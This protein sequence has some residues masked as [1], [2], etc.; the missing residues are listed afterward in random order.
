MMTIYLPNAY[1]ML[2]PKISKCHIS[3]TLLSLNVDLIFFSDT[4]YSFSQILV[5][6][7]SAFYN[8]LSFAYSVMNS[9]VTSVMDFSIIH[10]TIYWFLKITTV[11]SDSII[12]GL[13]YLVGNR[14]L[15]L[16]IRSFLSLVTLGS[17]FKECTE[18]NNIGRF[19]ITNNFIQYSLQDNR[20]SASFRIGIDRPKFILTTCLYMTSSSINFSYLSADVKIML[21]YNRFLSEKEDFKMKILVNVLNTYASPILLVNIF[22]IVFIRLLSCKATNIAP[23]FTPIRKAFMKNSITMAVDTPAAKIIFQSSRRIFTSGVR[24]GILSDICH[25]STTSVKLEDALHNKRD[26]L[27]HKY[28]RLFLNY[29]ETSQFVP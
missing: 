23:S 17:W 8:F 2:S 18:R 22:F 5:H 7:E 26:I 10:V 11:A 1:F 6:P 24:F 19:I 3:H 4:V 16:L 9:R 15:E 28:S 29:N 13:S 14:G 20:E 27:I 25:W 21:E 12:K